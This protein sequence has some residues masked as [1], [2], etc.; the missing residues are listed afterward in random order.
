[1]G[2][3]SRINPRN[4]RIQI[5]LT[6]ELY[7]ILSQ[8]SEITGDSMSQLT[9]E[10]LNSVTPGLKTQLK[11]LKTASRL[12]EE[13]NQQLAEALARHER[14]LVQEVDY[15]VENVEETIRQYKLPIT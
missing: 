10:V 5:N 13:G 2:T 8:I 11:L 4:R 15:T 12:K 7:S 6:Q 1:M 14:H 3:R 9:W